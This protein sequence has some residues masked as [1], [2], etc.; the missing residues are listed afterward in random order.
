MQ[1]A[2]SE[3]DVE[4][5][6]FVHTIPLD[7]NLNVMDSGT[8]AGRLYVISV[9]YDKS[10]GGYEKVFYLTSL[11]DGLQVY[12]SKTTEELAEHLTEGNFHP[13]SGA[14]KDVVINKAADVAL[15]TR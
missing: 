5:G 1:I 13:M 14:D 6:R 4:C 9:G 11:A 3:K 7:S 15:R 10:G 8:K 2:W 12:R